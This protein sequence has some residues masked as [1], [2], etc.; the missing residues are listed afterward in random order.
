MHIGWDAIQLLVVAAEHRS[1]SRAARI[2][3]V[4]QPTVSRRLAELEAE[5]GEA[6]FVR[7]ASG[8][9][10]TSTAERLLE[11]ARRMAESF[12]EVARIASG[13]RAGPRGTVRITSPPGVAFELLAPFAARARRAYPDIRLEVSATVRSLDLVRG[14]ADLALRTQ[15]PTTKALACLASLEEPLAAF[16]T[17]DYRAR[18]PVG[19]GAADV[20]WIAW[21]PT[22]AELP[23]NAQ[24]AARIPDFEPVFTS[25]DF[26]VQLRAAEA[27]VGA[28]VLS[29]FVSRASLPSSLVELELDVGRLR[30]ELHLLCAPSSLAIAR[31]RAVADLLRKELTV[32]ARV[33]RA[34]FAR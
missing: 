11:P 14:E 28:V 3:G 31:V 4:T 21:P 20:D 25:D 8:V 17:E 23:P 27:G 33:P 13:A 10:L 5:I 16:A 22:H 34:R 26:L 12:G 24:L 2:L 15:K 7:S 1:L 6:L 19:Y 32:R 9:A 18:L 29:R 30:A